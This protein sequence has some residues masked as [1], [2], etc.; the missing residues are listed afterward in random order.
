MGL[1]HTDPAKRLDPQ[2]AADMLATVA[3]ALPYRA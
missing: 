1:L 2:R 3:G